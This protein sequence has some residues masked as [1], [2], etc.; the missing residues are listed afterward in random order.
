MCATL[1]T[2]NAYHIF[3]SLNSTGVPLGPSDLIRNFVFMHM[4]P[5]DQDEFDRSYGGR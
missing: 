2:E 1:E 5:D 3:K 4:P